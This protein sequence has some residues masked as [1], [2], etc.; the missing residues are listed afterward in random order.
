MSTEESK[1][2][3]EE[4]PEYEEQLSKQQQMIK[5][6]VGQVDPETKLRVGEGRYTYPNQFFQYIGQWEHGK[7]NGFGTLLMRDGSK[8]F[9]QFKDGEITGAGERTWQD[10]T[11]YKGEWVM[12]EK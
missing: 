3:I 8:Y 5:T 10:G 7:K 1:A 12:G 9:G 6:Y 11:F 2:V 4:Q